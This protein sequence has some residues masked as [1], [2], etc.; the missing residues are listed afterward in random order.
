MGEYAA[1]AIQA[2]LSGRPRPAFRYRDKGQLAVIGRRRAVADLRR[3]KA[4]GTPAWLLWLFVHIFFLIGFR[5]R[6]LV[7]IEWAWSYFTFQGGARLI[8][9]RWEPAGGGDR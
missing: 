6:V 7:F 1:T 4:S 2:D 8:T 3:I 5:N 9:G